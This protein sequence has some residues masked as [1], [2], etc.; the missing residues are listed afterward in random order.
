VTA[1]EVARQSHA[2]GSAHGA[3]S[4]P[5]DLDQALPF[6]TSSGP[7]VIST[8]VAFPS[9]NGITMTIGELHDRFVPQGADDD[10]SHNRGTARRYDRRSQAW[11]VVMGR[12]QSREER[13]GC[14]WLIR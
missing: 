8:I 12:G 4:L 7:S 1:S 11:G 9:L 5:R 2:R 14:P 6:P 13:T 3:D 10:R